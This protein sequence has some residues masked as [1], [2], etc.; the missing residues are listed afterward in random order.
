MASLRKPYS[1]QVLS[2]EE[3]FKFCS[4]EIKCISYVFVPLKEVERNEAKLSK[5]LKPVKNYQKQEHIT[6]LFH[7]ILAS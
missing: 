7:K 2:A 1:D 5:G 3:M 4:E 6:S